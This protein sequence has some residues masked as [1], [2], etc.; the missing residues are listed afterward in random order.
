M[1]DAAMDPPGAIVAA[2]ASHINHGLVNPALMSQTMVKKEVVFKHISNEPLA[3]IICLS[4]LLIDSL[5]FICF[6]MVRTRASTASALEKRNV[7]CVF[8]NLYSFVVYL[9]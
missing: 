6:S 4:C 3:Y 8:Y 9:K 7:R 1:F 5:Y 2:P